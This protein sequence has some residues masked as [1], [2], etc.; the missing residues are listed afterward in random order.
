MCSWAYADNDGG[1]WCGKQY[2]PCAGC[3]GENMVLQME[4]G[5]ILQMYRDSKSKFKQVKILAE[6][7][8][9]SNK[10]MA[11]WLE[12]HGETVDSR[13]FPDRRMKKKETP[14]QEIEVAVMHEDGT[15]KR[16]FDQTAKADAGKL[17][18]SLVPTGII[19]AIARIRMYG[20]SKYGDPDNW[21]TVEP[22]RYRD[23]M[24]RHLLDYIEDPE[25][26]D[27]ESGLPSLWHL[28]CNA[29][30]LIEMEKYK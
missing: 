29:A 1:M 2:A 18:L 23:A 16:H 21:K 8:C 14:D 13:F 7:T 19:R 28:A 24:Y 30:F 11:Q 3:E 22:Q 10:E 17:Q 12:E 26:V 9:I 25:A 27:E 15:V 5:E 20:N 4:P 6:M